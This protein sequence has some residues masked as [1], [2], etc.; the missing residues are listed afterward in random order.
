MQQENKHAFLELKIITGK[1]IHSR[2]G[3]VIKPVVLK[4][5]KD[6]G[7]VYHGSGKGGTVQVFVV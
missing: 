2:K 1:G 3:A 5:L 7:M 6:S 4:F